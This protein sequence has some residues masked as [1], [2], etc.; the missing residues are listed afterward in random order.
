ME[1]AGLYLPACAYI[2]SSVWP[3]LSLS[4]LKRST[5]NVFP[6]P[7]WA[8]W[9]SSSPSSQDAS[10]LSV[11]MIK[12][13]FVG[14]SSTSILFC[15]S[16]CDDL[17]RYPSSS[18]QPGSSCPQSASMVFCIHLLVSMFSF[19]RLLIWTCNLFV[20]S[21]ASCS[22]PIPVSIHAHT[23]TCNLGSV[24]ACVRSIGCACVYLPMC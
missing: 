24:H 10:R 11:A 5:A 8:F 22:P 4:Y 17:S 23:M 9:M 3:I 12:A 18:A 2:C 20:Y 1:P 13:V 21:N 16:G 14:H 15:T 6:H 19:V 7:I